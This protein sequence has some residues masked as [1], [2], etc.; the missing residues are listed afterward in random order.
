MSFILFTC[1]NRSNMGYPYYDRRQGP[2]L[3]YSS[4]QLDLGRLNK[5]GLFAKIL[6][7]HRSYQQ[8]FEAE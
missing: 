8:R 2:A 6:G 7:D 3:G 1:L 5:R 4:V